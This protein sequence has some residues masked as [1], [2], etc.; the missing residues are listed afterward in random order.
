[1]NSLTKWSQNFLHE[2]NWLSDCK[3]VKFF[4]TKFS[5]IH[6]HKIF[7]F[8]V[9]IINYLFQGFMCNLRFLQ[10][11]SGISKCF[12]LRL[13]GFKIFKAFFLLN[14]SHNNRGLIKTIYNLCSINVMVPLDSTWY[15]SNIFLGYFGGTEVLNSYK[16]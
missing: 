2:P 3:A 9:D 10:E 15:V 12:A 11:V 14:Y 13:W 4:F 5:T 1:M 7:K 6:N 8:D 16:P